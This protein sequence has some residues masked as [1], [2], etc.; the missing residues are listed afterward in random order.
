METI[1]PDDWYQL[2]FD[3]VTPK[4]T[5]QNISKLIAELKTQ[6]LITKWFYLFEGN[7]IR[8]RLHSNR[9]AELEN[10]INEAT[11]GL[12]LTISADHPFEGYWETTE[13]FSNK[14]MATTFADVMSVVTELT[15]TRVEGAT[16]SNY[17][18]TERLSHCIFNN[19]Y[20]S[21]TEAYFMLKRIGID[22]Q[23]DDDPEQTVID[24]DQQYRLSN[25]TSV[26]IQPT[27]VPVKNK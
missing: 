23:L 11:Q 3:I 22:L 1:K 27:K 19:V 21:D 12:G 15:I 4:T 18:L 7:T 10:T 2:D 14:E 6:N 13:A 17:K 9:P 25:P 20:G 8:V 24:A 16:F 26:T 5:L